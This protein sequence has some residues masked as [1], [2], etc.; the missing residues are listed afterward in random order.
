MHGTA[1]QQPFLLAFSGRNESQVYHY[2]EKK[3]LIPPGLQWTNKCGSNGSSSRHVCY[4]KCMPLPLICHMTMYYYQYVSNNFCGSFVSITYIF[5]VAQLQQ[6]T[7]YTSHF[8][9]VSVTNADLEITP[10]FSPDHSADS[11]TW[12]VT[13]SIYIASCSVFEG[14]LSC[15]LHITYITICC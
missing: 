7:T 3:K 11:Q 4:C 2:H 9:P 10:F 8:Q 5:A 13:V 15:T 6:K 1:R 12:L 14:N